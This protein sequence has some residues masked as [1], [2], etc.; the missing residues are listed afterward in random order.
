MADIFRLSRMT[1]VIVLGNS[2]VN[3]SAGMLEPTIAPYLEIL[4]LTNSEIGLI[5][6]ARF[7]ITALASLPLALFASL[8]S[9]FLVFS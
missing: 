9:F 7:L 2:L 6:S 8:F 5:L 4:G 3:L 1:Y